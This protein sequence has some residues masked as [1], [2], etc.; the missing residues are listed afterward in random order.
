M[1]SKSLPLSELSLSESDDDHGR[2]CRAADEPDNNAEGDAGDDA[3]DDVDDDADQVVSQEESLEEL[4]ARANELLFALARIE[5][6]DQL[7]EGLIAEIKE[8]S[9]RAEQV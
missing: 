8:L 9:S 3:S 1:K 2:H 7:I 5:Q 4:R 6:K